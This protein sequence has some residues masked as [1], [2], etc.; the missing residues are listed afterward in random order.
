MTTGT[1]ETLEV[2]LRSRGISL[3][4]SVHD[5]GGTTAADGLQRLRLLGE[6]GPHPQAFTFKRMFSPQGEPVER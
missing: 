6:K 4:K 2:A 1:A 5:H 3:A